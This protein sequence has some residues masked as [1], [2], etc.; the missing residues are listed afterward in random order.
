M[1]WTIS[2]P[3]ANRRIDSWKEIASFFRRDERTVK[4]WEKSKFL[5]IHRIPGSERGGVF[6]YT[7]ELSDWLNTPLPAKR[8]LQETRSEAPLKSI[9]ASH[10]GVRP[11]SKAKLVLSRKSAATSKAEASA[12]VGNGKSC[13]IYRKQQS[14]SAV[15]YS[16]CRHASLFGWSSAWN[17]GGW[18]PFLLHQHIA[19]TP[20]QEKPVWHI[21]FEEIRSAL[22][23]DQNNQGGN[24][25]VIS[26]R[27]NKSTHLLCELVQVWGHYSCGSTSMM[28]HL[29]QLAD[30]VT[31]SADGLHV[32]LQR[33]NPEA[34]QP[35]FAL[36]CTGDG[37]VKDGSVMGKWPKSAHGDSDSVLLPQAAF[38]YFAAEARKI[39]KRT[40]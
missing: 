32:S 34:K 25:L 39:V 36:T 17:R 6:A 9:T 5:P 14:G 26:F 3:R 29:K 30:G 13:S 31:E 15:S 38:E 18:L 8:I 23:A 1:L 2:D 16:F 40:K 12:G 21:S 24:A 27:P 35:M 19:A 4:R 7:D 20:D 28:L 10:T 11:R 22:E 33:N 37:F